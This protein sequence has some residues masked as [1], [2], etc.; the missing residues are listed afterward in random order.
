MEEEPVNEF[1]TNLFIY[2]EIQ[3][4]LRIESKHGSQ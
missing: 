1:F 2:A 4:K 3:E